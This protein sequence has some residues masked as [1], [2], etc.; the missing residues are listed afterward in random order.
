[1]ALQELFY[2]AESLGDFGIGD[3]F[4][5]PG[6]GFGEEGRAAGWTRPVLGNSK[7]VSM[8]ND[9]SYVHDWVIRCKDGLS[10][11]LWLPKSLCCRES[12]KGERMR[13]VAQ[14]V[15]VV[16]MRKYS[17]LATE[18]VTTCL[19]QSC[20]PKFLDRMSGCVHSGGHLVLCQNGGEWYEAY[21]TCG[22]CG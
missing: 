8:G 1:M 2:H 7:E 19:R 5:R 6:V 20:D 10:L 11:R 21:R 15:R 13:D 9:P 18:Y 22:V 12:R 4:D 14:C 3:L 16:R 17:L